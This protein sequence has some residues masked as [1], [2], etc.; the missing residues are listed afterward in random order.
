MNFTVKDIRHTAN[1]DLEITYVHFNGG[2]PEWTPITSGSVLLVGNDGALAATVVSTPADTIRLRVTDVDFNLDPAQIDTAPVVV[3]NG[4]TGELEDVLLQELSVD[5]D[6][7][8]GIVRSVSAAG[9]GVD[10]DGIFNTQDGDSLFIT[11]VDS[12]TAAGTQVSLLDTNF[13]IDPLGD[14]DGNGMA[15]AFDAARILAHAVGYI[16]LAGRDSMA[17]NVDLQAPFGPITSFDATLVIQKRLG[18]IGRFPIQEDEADN[19]P[20]PETDASVPKTAP[21]I[22]QL[23]LVQRS[24]YVAIGPRSARVSSRVT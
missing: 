13:V 23:A 16:T 12:L 14:A 6:V 22:R 15:Q 20:Q 1:S 17:A 2:R 7:F 19:H 4:T 18:L 11:F 21:Q 9:A 8:F 10:S 3:V 5:D 24:G